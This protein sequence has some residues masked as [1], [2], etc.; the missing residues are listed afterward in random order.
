MNSSH[1]ATQKDQKSHYLN[2]VTSEI[3]TKGRG[4]GAVSDRHPP[5]AA[6][7]HVW[8]TGDTSNQTN[9]LWGNT[10]TMKDTAA[11]NFRSNL[12]S[13]ADCSSYALTNPATQSNVS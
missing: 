3:S 13:R 10:A 2:Y 11:L 6:D 1:T 12:K 7:L 5:V 8:P 4:G 9:G